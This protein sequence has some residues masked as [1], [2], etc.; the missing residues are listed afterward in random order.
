MSLELSE[1]NRV[2]GRI[3]VLWLYYLLKKPGWAWLNQDDTQF[4]GLV[5][6]IETDAMN[7]RF[8][9]VRRYGS[10]AL[11][12][13]LLNLNVTADLVTF[14]L[15]TPYVYPPTPCFG[16]DQALETGLNV[17]R[18]WIFR[19]QQ[20]NLSSASRAAGMV[21]QA[22]GLPTIDVLDLLEYI[23]VGHIRKELARG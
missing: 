6:D 23:F 3:A 13:F 11:E 17:L 22:L 5:S 4:S 20:I 7:G 2:R 8:G 15:H 12:E 14:P 19:Q 9:M 1:V 18:Y 21:A 10:N 16:S